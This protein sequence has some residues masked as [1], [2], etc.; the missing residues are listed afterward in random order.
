MLWCLRCSSWLTTRERLRH[1]TTTCAWQLVQQSF[2]VSFWYNS[3]GAPRVWSRSDDV[4]QVY[5][6]ALAG[7]RA[8]IDALSHFQ[9]GIGA[10]RS[11][12]GWIGQ[13][14]SVPINDED[15]RWTNVPTDIE[16]VDEA[17]TLND[18]TLLDQN[19]ILHLEQS[20]RQHADA[21][22]REVVASSEE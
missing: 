13:K 22:F 10:P 1:E 12:T 11:L 2:D 19:N 18:I 6:D 21:Q 20:V 8:M 16:D 7:A 3:T 17:F 9:F 4:Q 15:S 5:E 14:P